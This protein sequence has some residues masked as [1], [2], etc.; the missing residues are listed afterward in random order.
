MTLPANQ[1]SDS[2]QRLWET[3][4]EEEKSELKMLAQQYLAGD[5]EAGKQLAE[6]LNLPQDDVTDR[7]VAVGLIVIGIGIGIMML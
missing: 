5:E 7:F 1:L 2:L 6:L 3:K 4:T